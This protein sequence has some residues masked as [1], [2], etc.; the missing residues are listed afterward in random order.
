M[1]PSEPP[2]VSQKA[3]FEENQ[4]HHSRFSNLD[5]LL[6]KK[7][8]A[9]TSISVGLPT[10]NEE[11][12]IGDI[13][14]TIHQT[15][16]EQHQLVDEL[17]VIDSGSTDQTRKI[18]RQEGATVYEAGNY[19][20]KTQGLQGKGVNLWLS[21]QLLSGDLICWV[22]TDIKNFHPRFVYG[23]IGPILCNEDIQF[24]KG[25]YER[26]IQIQ[27]QLQSSGGGRVTELTARPLL[28][29][30]FPELRYFAQPLSGEY[31]GERSVFEQIPFFP[32]YGVETGML[33]D[34]VMKHGLENIVQVNLDRRVHHNKP[35]NRLR[36][37][38][39][40]I[41]QVVLHRARQHNRF[42]NDMDEKALFTMINQKENQLD[43]ETCES[44]L[45]VLPA[46]HP[47]EK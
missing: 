44:Q 17:A 36:K 15:F 30:F 9:S 35:L 2:D 18:A 32:E 27:D 39:F 47:T 10:Y 21:L 26:P 34:M 40:R 42:S 43:V 20:D 11:E 14:Q 7:N 5:Q 8:N 12:T 13:V 6:Q 22:D 3:W 37:M 25:F 29:I 45:Q 23:L 24:A 16:Q 28:N 19:Q 33:I 46:L 41:L 31:A 38:A 1:A 4:K